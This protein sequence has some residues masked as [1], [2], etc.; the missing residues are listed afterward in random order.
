VDG[1]SRVDSVQSVRHEDAVVSVGSTVFNQ[2]RPP[3]PLSCLSSRLHGVVS[4]PVR[5]YMQRV[6]Q[7]FI[8]I[9]ASNEKEA[10]ESVDTRG[11]ARSD[12]FCLTK[13]G[14]PEPSS[15]TETPT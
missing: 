13:L 7:F 11:E 5:R 6:S 3:S 2:L 9:H 8:L 15:C 12:A 14:L 1:M 4:S 10:D